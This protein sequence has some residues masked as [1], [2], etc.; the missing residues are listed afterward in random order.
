MKKRK[1]APP[2]IWRK[3]SGPWDVCAYGCPHLIEHTADPAV[4][5]CTITG[6]LVRLRSFDVEAGAWHHICAYCRRLTGREVE[7]KQLRL[8]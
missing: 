2:V 6:K 3:G 5:W 7:A 1:P 8:F 4:A